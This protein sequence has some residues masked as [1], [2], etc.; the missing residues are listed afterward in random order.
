L[1]TRTE[2][3]NS[4]RRRLKVD[5]GVEE[6]PVEEAVGRVLAE[7]VV[8]P[9]D[10]PPFDS[11]AVDGYAVRASDTFG[12][13]RNSPRLI[14]AEEVARVV[15]GGPVPEGFDAVVP[16]ESAELKGRYLEVY[17]PV[18]RWGNLNRRGFDVAKGQRVL[19]RGRRVR[20]WDI[21]LLLTMGVER[22]KVFRRLKAAIYPVGDELAEPPAPLTAGRRPESNSFMIAS[23]LKSKGVKVCTRRILRDEV[24]GIA[25]ALAEGL[26]RADIVV[27]LGGTSVGKKDLTVRAAGRLGEVIA[28]GISMRP[29]KPTALA[30]ASGKP[31]FCLSGYPVAALVG[32]KVFVEPAVDRMLGLS[33]T[34]KPVRGRLALRVPSEPGVTDFVR[35]SIHLEGGEPVI[36]PL[37]RGGSSLYSSLISSEGVI[38]IPYELEGFEEGSHVPFLF[39]EDPWYPVL[40]LKP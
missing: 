32:Y 3:W 4:L 23:L 17:S 12:A 40:G 35:A 11:S 26:R 10:L 20:P 15:T 39:H 13:T 1:N 9:I 16:V 25:E 38:I 34:P 19:R 27:T 22:V 6:V 29:G 37:R 18:P 8:A 24:D 7:D 5:V 33:S 36:K 30:V 21:S 14:K 31:I 28:H 2:A